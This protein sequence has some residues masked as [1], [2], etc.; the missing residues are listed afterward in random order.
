MRALLNRSEGRL[1]EIFQSLVVLDSPSNIK[2]DKLLDPVERMVAE[3]ATYLK[4]LEK[5]DFNE[6]GVM[7]F[8]QIV[9]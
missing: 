4:D 8:T 9:W 6:S 3:K 7:H 2:I 5:H 1:D